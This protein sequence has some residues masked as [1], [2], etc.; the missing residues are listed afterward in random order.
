MKH[1]ISKIVVTGK[2]EQEVNPPAKEYK[3]KYTAKQNGEYEIQ[4][5]GANGSLVSQKIE[6][7]NIVEI[8]AAKPY[9]PAGF[10]VVEGEKEP[11]KGM[12]I[13]D[14]YRQ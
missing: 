12:V 6:I 3:Y 4:A 14:K 10:T 5:I 1:G 8:S 13:K 9:I 7:K 11:L 2:T